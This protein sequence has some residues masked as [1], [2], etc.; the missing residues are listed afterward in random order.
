[1]E[2]QDQKAGN[3]SLWKGGLNI[4][5]QSH[6]GVQ[7]QKRT[8]ARLAEDGFEGRAPGK[9]GVR[10]FAVGWAAMWL[11]VARPASAQPPRRHHVL[12]ISVDGMR[13]TD[14]LAPSRGS[15]I[16]TLLWLKNHGSYAEGV[17]GV[18]PAVTYPSH[19]TIVTGC[20]PSQ[21]GIY[22]NYSSRVAGQNPNDWFWFSK[23]IQCKTLWD[24]AREHDLT[25]AS[26][27][28]PV[29]A[30][31]AIDW[32]LPEIWDPAKP[33][34]P[35]PLYVAK[36]MNPVFALEL[37]AAL[38]MPQPNADSDDLRTRVAIYV[39]EKHKP[40]LTLVHLAD[41]DQAQHAFG[42]GTPQAIGTLNG[43]DE[44]IGK[45][46]GAVKQAGLADDTDVFIVSDHGF[47]AVHRVVHPNALLVKANLL[48][49]SSSGAVT[50]GKIDT[51][52]NGG[53]FFI[54]WPKD[55]HL[56]AAIDRALKPL[57]DRDLAWAVIGPQ[58]LRDLGADPRVRLAL[59]A[60]SGAMFDANGA[61]P[62]VTELGAENGDHGYLPFR[63]GMAASFIAWGPDIK[64]G[65][66]LHF[67]RMTALG[68]TILK[69]M[70][71]VDA[72]FGHREPLDIWLK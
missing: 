53:S 1:M 28:W 66:D 64:V 13:S 14:Y 54:Y 23:A 10:A 39:I 68:P 27:S 48:S 69:A 11:W 29:T 31:A 33:P 22:T 34:A 15:E 70:G 32:D 57:R 17:K 46:L 60:P 6:H 9:W 38:G 21:H 18:Y 43:I 5:A 58:A 7:E 2:K 44:R 37:F 62:L 3:R 8:K 72:R 12:V 19:T 24:E 30:G 26:I 52:S 61:G 56:K 35:E 59:D 16:P 4:K 25:T 47:V 55:E 63:K 20:L 51:V 65:C 42:P 40:D 45:I 71:I 36:F 50:G 49:A 67:V 41:L